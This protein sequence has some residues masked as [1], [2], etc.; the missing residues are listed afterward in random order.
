MR[1]RKSH[2]LKVVIVVALKGARASQ[3]SVHRRHIELEGRGRRQGVSALTRNLL[4]NEGV[5]RGEGAEPSPVSPKT[6]RYDPP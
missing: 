4:G 6:L 5:P 3:S 1:N 2:R